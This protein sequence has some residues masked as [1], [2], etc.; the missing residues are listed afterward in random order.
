MAGMKRAIVMALVMLLPFAQFACLHDDV[1]ADDAVEQSLLVD[2][3]DGRTSWYDILPGDSLE[4]MIA[5]T[6]DDVEVLFVDSAQGRTIASIDGKEVVTVGTSLNRQECIWRVYSWNSVEWE[7]ITA[8]VTDR[9]VGG[10]IALG[11]YPNDTLKPAS[12]PEYR[13]V[14]T[15]YRGD[16]SSSGVSGSEGPE[17]VSTPL[18]WY[19]TYPGAVDS[20][21]LYAD[22]MIYHTSSGKY[23]SV[24]MDNLARM[25]CLDP[26]NKEVLW[27]V[28]YS[29]SGNIEITTPVI[30]GDLIM[31]T[32]GNW[33]IYCLDRFTGEAVAE[34]APLGEEGDMCSGSKLSNYIPR[35]DDPSVSGDRVHLEAGVTN[36]VYDSGALYFCTS[37]GLVRCFSIDREN[38]FKEI[39]SHR[40]DSDRGCFYYYPPIIGEYGDMSFVLA[41]NCGGGL[42]CV[43]SLT[44]EGIWSRTLHDTDGDKVGQ[45]SSISLCS[46]GRA[47]VC[48][49]SGEMSS[50][51]GGVMLIDIEDGSTIWQYDIRCGKTTVQGDRFYAYVSSSGS[52]TVKDY[53]TGQD[54]EVVSGYY[55]F[56]VDDCSCLWSK[57]TDAL[58]IGG[59]TYC[60]GRLYSIDYS[61][62]TEGALGGWV[63]CMDSDTGSTVWKTKVSPYSGGAYSMCLPT[64]VD[65]MVL[66]GNDYGAVYILS[67]TSGSDRQT[68]SE[69]VYKSAGLGH[70][71]WIAMLILTAAGAAI[72]IWIYRR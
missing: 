25:N 65:G 10:C 34:L 12:N 47:L 55:S 20:S 51:G 6:V 30:V 68:S 49:S 11:F 14:W 63:W 36:A 3:G 16:S 26:V 64:V 23:G 19:V 8:D 66:V 67:E 7:F 33:H 17:F 56:W 28:T 5:A 9:Y 41:G 59:V 72:A 50:A 42:I 37:D 69:I 61:P 58:S 1:D 21:I 27:S 13:T 22:G 15:S 2:Y 62:G 54:M 38:G 71:S 31:V 46:D 40:P 4:S 18:E 32:S 60:D 57:G 29:N 52:E 44:G 39:W 43:D 70:W 48:Y 53:R 35:K 24:G 45:V